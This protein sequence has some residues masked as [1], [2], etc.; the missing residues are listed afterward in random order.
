MVWMFGAES[1]GRFVIGLVKSVIGLVVD[2]SLPLASLLESRVVRI[3]L[4]ERSTAKL[5]TGLVG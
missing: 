5:R 1:V 2:L 3:T 4:T